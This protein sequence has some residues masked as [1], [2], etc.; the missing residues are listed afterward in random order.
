M[1]DEYYNIVLKNK[2]VILDSICNGIMGDYNGSTPFPRSKQ[3]LIDFIKENN[4]AILSFRNKSSQNI[5]TAR[6]VKVSEI[7]KII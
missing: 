2:T 4:T 3:D 6:G 7:L 5:S 1:K